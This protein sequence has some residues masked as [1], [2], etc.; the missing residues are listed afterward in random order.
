MSANETGALG[1]AI[2]SA[3]AVGDYPDLSAAAAAM[4]RIAEPVYPNPAYQEIYNRK[5]ALYC[6]TI[7]A[8]DPLWA[9]M[10]ALIET[11]ASAQP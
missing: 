8:L 5:Y 4:S 2:A 10:Q 1:C 11:G 7:D 9:D 6:K 3:V